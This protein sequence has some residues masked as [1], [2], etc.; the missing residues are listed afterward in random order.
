MYMIVAGLCVR[1]GIYV[2]S[3]CMYVYMYMLVGLPVLMLC[4]HFI[5]VG[6]CVVAGLCSEWDIYHI[7]N[8]V[9][10]CS[11]LVFGGL[12]RFCQW[13]RWHVDTSRHLHIWLR[14]RDT[15]IVCSGFYILDLTSTSRW[16]HRH[17]SIH[18]V[19][20]ARGCIA[21]CIAFTYLAR[22]CIVPWFTRRNI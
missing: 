15:H 20:N 14:T 10:V 4:V 19:C 16:D 17:G 9:Y 6:P 22:Y 8:I 1:T 5:C 11:W 21:P 3:G 2:I 12:C 18:C 13:S 7:S